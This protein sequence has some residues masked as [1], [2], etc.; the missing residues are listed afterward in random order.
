MSYEVLIRGLEVQAQIGVSK[1]ERLLARPLVIDLD[2]SVEGAAL[3]SDD[4]QDT[5]DYGAVCVLVS[6]LVGQRPRKTLERLAYEIVE[7]LLD[8]F[9][10]VTQ[11]TIELFKP[12][13]PVLANAASAGVRLVKTRA[14]HRND[15][16]CHPNG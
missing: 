13:P 12:N 16:E 7:R 11:A 4:V 10:S 14:N 15:A 1:E 3:V 2:L 9:P 5:V 8:T 6:E